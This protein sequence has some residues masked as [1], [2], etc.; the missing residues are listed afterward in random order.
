MGIQVNL[1]F[2]G[3]VVQ[4]TIKLDVYDEEGNSVRVDEEGTWYEVVQAGIKWEENHYEV[5]C[6]IVRID[7]EAEKLP[8][9]AFSVMWV[10]RHFTF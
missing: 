2:P 4:S 9:A 6:D 1:P 10:E 3:E 5:I 7:D 8:E